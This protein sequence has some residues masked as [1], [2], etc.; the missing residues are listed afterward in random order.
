M[1]KHNGSR[2]KLSAETQWSWLILS[3]ALILGALVRFMPAVLLP[4]PPGDGGMFYEATGNILAS[5]WRLPELITY[6]QLDIPFAYPPF[7]FYAAALIEKISGFGRLDIFRFLPPFYSLLAIL[8][9]YYLAN[10][11][12]RSRPQAALAAAL[13]ALL[14]RSLWII[15]GGGIVRAPGI[16][17]PILTIAHLYRVCFKDEP[18]AKWMV[19]IFGSLVI[20]THPESAIHT[21]GVCLWLLLAAPVKRASFLSGVQIAAAILLLTSPWW[22]TVLLRYG[23]EPIRSAMGTGGFDA[24]GFFV[25]PLNN[26]GEELFLP[27]ITIT[28]FWGA[29]YKIYKKEFLLPVWLCVPFFLSHRSG[30]G[31]AII[32][33]VLLGSA[34]ICEFLIPA[35]AAARDKTLMP[36][37][38]WE[39]KVSSITKGIIGIMIIYTFAGAVWWSML[40]INNHAVSQEHRKAMQ[41]VREST[42]SNARFLLLTGDSKNGEEVLEWFPTVTDRVSLTT[43]QGKEW[44][45][46]NQY[47]RALENTKQLQSECPRAGV[48]CLD[49][50]VKANQ[51]DYE[52]IYVVNRPSSPYGLPILNSLAINSY[53]KPVYTSPKQ[54][55]WIYQRQ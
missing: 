11:I 16:I 18:K 8:A 4:F 47:N 35:I 6:N 2:K 7:G 12:F 54:E 52:Y 14:P 32:P 49:A 27:V 43:T 50:W 5:G 34:C 17:F 13:Y 42:P 30:P 53:Y 31:Y 41:W 25:W 3:L 48:N 24:F 33:L 46:N 38:I 23:I 40:A 55:V 20:L 29:I 26:I 51:V 36:E 21:A 1:N 9:I 15:L 10:V 28:A 44:L 39:G 37:N 45:S 19:I 22:L